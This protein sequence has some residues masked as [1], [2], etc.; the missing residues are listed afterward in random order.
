MT[1]STQ[2]PVH[3]ITCFTVMT[4]HD[5][6]KLVNL[7]SRPGCTLGSSL[8]STVSVLK[9]LPEISSCTCLSEG[10]AISKLK[11]WSQSDK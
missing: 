8:G 4:S 1:K 3:S 9:T 7:A 6:L 5:Q 2:L 11:P 10:Y